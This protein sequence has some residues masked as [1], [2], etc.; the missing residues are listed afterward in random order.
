MAGLGPRVTGVTL[1]P[2]GYAASIDGRVIERP[3]VEVHAVDTTGC[4]DVFHA[5]VTYGI[6]R[7]WG[8]EK[9]LDFGAWAAAMSSARLGG[10]EGIP[11]AKA[12]ENEGWRR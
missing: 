8:V 5:G 12:I 2:K 7:G 1:G 11:D 10:R 6:V 4:G 9:S 3:A